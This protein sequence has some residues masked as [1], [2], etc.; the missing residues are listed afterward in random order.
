MTEKG[1]KLPLTTKTLQSVILQEHQRIEQGT[2]PPAVTAAYT[3]VGIGRKDD[4]IGVRLGHVH[5]ARV[6][7]AYRHVGVLRHKL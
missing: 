6:G 3:Q 1:K 2:N 4:G 7:E 5:E